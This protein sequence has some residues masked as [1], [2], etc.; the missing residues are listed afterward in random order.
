MKTVAERMWEIA[1]AAGTESRAEM[2]SKINLKSQSMYQWYSEDEKRRTAPRAATIKAFCK[3]YN[4]SELELLTGE[5]NDDR[6][7]IMLSRMEKQLIQ[8]FRQLSLEEQEAILDEVVDL[9]LSL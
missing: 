3:E 2:A 6:P 1:K 8:G 7:R 9:A 5:K 4:V